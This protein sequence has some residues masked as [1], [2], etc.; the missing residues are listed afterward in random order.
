MARKQD[1]SIENNILHF[2]Y[3][4]SDYLVDLDQLEMVYLFKDCL[5]FY[6]NK[7]IMIK[8][9]KDEISKILTLI[10]KQPNFIKCDFNRIVNTNLIE[11]IH[12]EAHKGTIGFQGKH[13]FVL[14]F[15]RGRTEEITV[16]SFAKAEKL[17]HEIDNKIYEAEYLQQFGN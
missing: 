8:V 1:I 7:R 4:D 9:E 16:D 11:H 5:C 13:G 3:N 2:V 14:T 17:Y 15:K 10:L 6:E 12:I